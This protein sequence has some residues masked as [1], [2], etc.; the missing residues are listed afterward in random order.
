[1]SQA[2][3]SRLAFLYSCEFGDWPERAATGLDFNRLL[4]E[5]YP[6][7]ENLLDHNDI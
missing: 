3:A 1:M 4:M 6:E 5:L 7:E 2:G